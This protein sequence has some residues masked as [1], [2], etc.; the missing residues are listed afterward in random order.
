MTPDSSGVWIQQ[1]PTDCYVS[2]TFLTYLNVLLPFIM[3]LSWLATVSLL[4][5][6][7][8]YE[9]E[10]RLKEV[11]RVMGL[12]NSIHWVSYFITTLFILIPVCFILCILL[13]VGRIFTF[14]DFSLILFFFLTY[15]VA[16]ITF[17]FLISTFFTKANLSGAVTAI[18][19]FL[20]WLP[21]LP[22]QNNSST[23]PQWAVFLICVFSNSAFSIIIKITAQYESQ[24]LGSRWD[25]LNRGKNAKMHLQLIQRQ[26]P[27]RAWALNTNM[28]RYY[29]LI[30]VY[31][32]IRYF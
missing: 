10:K 30:P 21:Y 32:T 28:D 4:V 29:Q 6:N 25:N 8:V 18:I 11:M 14:S 7:I 15:A 16:T 5:K 9:K 27:N 22:Y 31:E 24:W 19:F 13:K 1:F 26:S 12:K 23:T 2:D 3:V 17:G 20:T